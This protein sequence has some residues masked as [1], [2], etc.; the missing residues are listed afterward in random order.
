MNVYN[1]EAAKIDLFFTRG[2]SMY[3]T[4]DDI[5][6]NDVAYDMTG[7]QIDIH[8]RSYDRRLIR[9][10]STVTGEIT[11]ATDS[12]TIDADGFTETGIYKYDV[13]VNDGTHTL[14]I[15]KGLLYV[16]EEQTE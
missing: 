7:F 8:V 4:F 11:I 15:M 13:Q 1:V 10:L 16:E 5:T 2:D 14:T 3:L 12:F 6:R 9:E